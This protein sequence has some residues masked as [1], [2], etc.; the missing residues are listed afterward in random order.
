MSMKR[1]IIALMAIMPLASMAQNT[2]EMP[3]KTEDGTVINPAEMER[4]EG[5]E[6]PERPDGGGNPGNMADMEVSTD[7][8]LTAEGGTFGNISAAE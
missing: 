6:R 1:L 3:E 5:G 7:F 2:W 4:P 8:V